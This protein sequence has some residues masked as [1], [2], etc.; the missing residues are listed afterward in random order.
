MA[1][2]IINRVQRSGIVTIDFEELF[3]K[4]ERLAFDI[5]PYL[6]QGLALKE[7]DFREFVAE[8]DWEQYQDKNIAIFCSVDAIVPT[9]AYMLLAA[10]LE[11]FANKITFGSIEELEKELFDDLIASYD[12]SEVEG[13]RVVVKGCSD[14]PIPLSAYVKI[15]AKIKPHVKALMF[16]EPCS[17]VPIYRKPRK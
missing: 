17:T 3:P 6:W 15:T 2:E 11:P 7:K 13:R 5:A 14:L 1:E 12:V 8:H 10:S 16:G 4:G 9:W